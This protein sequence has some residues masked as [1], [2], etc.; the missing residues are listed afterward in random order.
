MSILFPVAISVVFSGVA[1][2]LL[3]RF[4]SLASAMGGGG[5]GQQGCISQGKH[6]QPTGGGKGKGGNNRATGTKAFLKNHHK[7]FPT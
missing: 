1:V 4:L 5:K 7:M 6:T 2:I 3:P